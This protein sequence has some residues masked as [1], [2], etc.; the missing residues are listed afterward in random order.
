MAWRPGALLSDGYVDAREVRPRKGGPLVARLH[1]DTLA[2]PV[3]IKLTVRPD[4]L[5]RNG[6]Y[7]ASFPRELAGQVFAFAREVSAVDT[8]SEGYMEGFDP[9]QT[10]ATLDYIRLDWGYGTG[11]T[12]AWY[13]ESNGR[14]CIEAD[15]MAKDLSTTLPDFREEEAA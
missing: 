12:I 1:L 3:T 7:P 13:G 8:K 6:K 10:D 5:R 4:H 11:L 9:D 2:E 15:G 14:V